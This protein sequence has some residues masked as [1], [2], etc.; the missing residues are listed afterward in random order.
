MVISNYLL[1]G[2]FIISLIVILERSSKIRNYIKKNTEIQE[3][4]FVFKNSKGLGHLT[5]II[6]IAFIINSIS[7]LILLGNSLFFYVFFVFTSLIELA[8]IE[9]LIIVTYLSRK[10]L[11]PNSTIK[12][13][14]KTNIYVYLSLIIYFI[15]YIYV[16]VP[17]FIFK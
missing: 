17:S 4:T 6:S 14:H 8:L 9:G 3:N 11:D 10:K 5:L 12:K 16:I 7:L 15:I 1:L 2:I 13:V